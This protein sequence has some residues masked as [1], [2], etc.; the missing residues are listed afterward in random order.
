MLMAPVAFQR[1]SFHQQQPLGLSAAQLT[2]L[3]ALK[4]G[5]LVG[6]LSDQPL[7]LINWEGLV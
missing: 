2:G 4:A 5:A 1:R 6:C 7:L 3:C